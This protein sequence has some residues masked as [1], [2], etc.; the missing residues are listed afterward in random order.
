MEIS[1]RA[2]FFQR[3]RMGVANEWDFI[4]SIIEDCEYVSAIGKAI[5]RR[6]SANR[7][8]ASNESGRV[9]FG[10]K[11]HYLKLPYSY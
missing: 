4:V 3:F 9:E 11:V 2:Y 7:S 1:K 6:T 8:P 10:Q 5:Q